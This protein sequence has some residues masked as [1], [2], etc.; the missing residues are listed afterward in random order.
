MNEGAGSPAPALEFSTTCIDTVAWL[1]YKGFT[2]SKV[3]KTGRR[4]RRARWVFLDPE[5]KI[6]RIVAEM[7]DAGELRF[8]R[9][10]KRK[11]EEAKDLME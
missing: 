8:A 1:E 5:G 7:V 11:I 10:R 2:S 6:P 9:I 3:E 4:G